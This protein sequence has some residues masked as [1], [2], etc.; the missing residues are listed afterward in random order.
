M[1]STT[2]PSFLV[3]RLFAQ[4][5]S[6]LGL[7]PWTTRGPPGAHATALLR[8]ELFES[9]LSWMV[10]G[11][12]RRC[13]LGTLTSGDYLLARHQRCGI[14]HCRVHSNLV[15][16]HKWLEELTKGQPLRGSSAVVTTLSSAS[17]SGTHLGEVPSPG[18]FP[19]IHKEVGYISQA[20]RRCLSHDRG[21]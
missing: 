19:Y 12:P 3:S 8:H 13:W 6:S 17:T 16:S 20:R 15:A 5:T 11:P 7:G 4:T 18:Y 9:V 1:V 2:S 14:I 10:Y 21:V